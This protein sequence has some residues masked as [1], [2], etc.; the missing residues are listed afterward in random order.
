MRLLTGLLALSVA[1]AAAAAA[2]PTPRDFAYGLDVEPEYG[3]PVQQLTVPE[4]VYQGVTRPD[5]GDLRVFNG[6]GIVV[7]HALCHGPVVTA[8]TVTE[9]PLLVFPLRRPPPLG[10]Q[11]GGRVS[12]QTPGGTS[13]QVIERAPSGALTPTV[14]GPADGFVVDA[15]DGPNA[16]RRLRLAWSTPDG[17][18]EAQVRVEASEDLN[19]WRTIVAGTTL[20]HVAA[21]GRALDRNTIDLPEAKYRYLRLV[22]SEGPAVEISGVSADVVHPAV[23]AAPQWFAA[24]PAAD[25]EASAFH[26]DAGRLAPVHAA[27]VELAM[28]NMALGVALDSRPRADAPWQQRWSGDVSSVRRDPAEIAFGVADNGTSTFAPVADT[29]WRVRVLRGAESLGGSR[30]TLRLGYHPAR[31]RFL[32]QGEGPF[33]VAYGSGR[34]PAAQTVSCDGLLP[35]A[36]AEARETLIGAASAAP[37]AAGAFGGPDVLAPPPKPT[38]VRQIVLWAVLLLGAAGLVAMALSLLRRLREGGSP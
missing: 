4:R 20:L 36:S 31:L 12:V 3:P 33:V 32:A 25:T 28:T 19:R 14:E 13:V 15:G 8:A 37:A 22:R 17:A 5:L 38:P 35:Q 7:P 26:Y 29:Q 21:D 18:S 6:G 11:G 30:P 10:A 2:A 1:V 16:L 34:V 9:Q 24:S 23:A 27:R